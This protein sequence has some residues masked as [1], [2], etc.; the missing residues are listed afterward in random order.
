MSLNN[1]IPEIWSAGILANTKNELVYA[2]SGLVNQDYASDLVSFGN[3][4]HIN[5]I[6]PVTVVPYYKN[7]G[8]TIVPEIL[9]DSQLTF[10]IDQADAFAFEIDDIDKRQVNQE[11]FSKYMGEAGFSLHQE[12][13]TFVR[14]LINAGV[15]GASAGNGN[16]LAN[17]T[18]NT[19]S[20]WDALYEAFVDLSVVLDEN[21]APSEGR[22]CVVSPRIHGV[23]LKDARFVS[24]GTDANRATIAS[25]AVGN[26]AGLNIYK[27]NRTPSD[28]SGNPIMLAGSSRAT[29]FAN[30][31]ESVEAFR[32]EARFSDAVKG[33]HVYGGK[34]IRPEFLAKVA[35]D[36]T[37]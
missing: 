24:F 30:N 32:P 28:G 7:Q 31:L 5:S 22:W 4:V 33:L 27:S 1:F 11:L 21:N 12:I 25:R 26:V 3:T 8:T 35:V 18:A 20:T 2:D 14:D 37:P 9:D 19:S 6:G 15:P 36:V 17:V 16:W 34:V 23:L 13:D 10:V 29:T